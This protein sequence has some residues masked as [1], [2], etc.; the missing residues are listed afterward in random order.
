MSTL[1]ET[2]GKMDCFPLEADLAKRLDEP[3]LAAAVRRARLMLAEAYKVVL[4]QSSATDASTHHSAQHSHT[5]NESTYTPTQPQEPATLQTA[6]WAVEA[7]DRADDVTVASAL[8]HVQV[9][10]H[11]SVSSSLLPRD[12]ELAQTSPYRAERLVGKVSVHPASALQSGSPEELVVAEQ[13]LRRDE[14]LESFR[15]KWGKAP[16]EETPGNSVHAALLAAYQLVGRYQQVP[17]GG[18]AGRLDENADNFSALSPGDQDTVLVAHRMLDRPLE[19]PKK[20]EGF[21]RELS[22]SRPKPEVRTMPQGGAPAIRLNHLQ[23][24]NYRMV[25]PAMTGYVVRPPVEKIDPGN[26]WQ[27]AL[28]LPRTNEGM[29]S[30]AALRLM[31]QYTDRLFDA[32]CALIEEYAGL[33]ANLRAADQLRSSIPPQVLAKFPE[34]DSFRHQAAHSPSVTDVVVDGTTHI[35]D[36][37]IAFSNMTELNIPVGRT[38]VSVHVD[39]TEP[40]HRNDR[41]LE[42]LITAVDM[43]QHAGYEIPDMEVY[44]PKYTQ[45]LLARPD[46]GI[47]TDRSTPPYLHSLYAEFTAPDRF[48]LSPRLLEADVERRRENDGT[49]KGLALQYDN[50]AVAVIIHEIGHFLQYQQ[51]PSRFFEFKTKWLDAREAQTLSTYAGTPAEY[52]AEYFLGKVMGKAFTPRQ[53]ALYAALGGAQP[54]FMPT[55]HPTAPQLQPTQLIHVTHEVNLQLQRRGDRQGAVTPDWVAA[56]YQRLP[57]DIKL[58]YTRLIAAALADVRQYGTVGRMLG[59]VQEVLAVPTRESERPLAGPSRLERGEIHNNSKNS[60][61]EWPAVSPRSAARQQ[62]ITRAATPTNLT[63]APTHGHTTSPDTAHK[64]QDPNRATTYLDA[65]RHGDTQLPFASR[66]TRSIPMSETLQGKV[67]AAVKISTKTRDEAI[68]SFR[69]KWVKAP[70]EGMPRNRVHAALLA[71]Y[72]LLGRYQ[73]VPLGGIATR[74]DEHADNFGELSPGDQDTVFLAYHMLEQSL[75]D[76]KELEDFAKTLG[77]SRPKPERRTMPRGGTPAA[78]M[79]TLASLVLTGSYVLQGNSNGAVTDRAGSV[80][81]TSDLEPCVAVC[82]HNGKLSFLIH[83]DST[84]NKGRGAIDLITSIRK[85]VPIQ[86]G[87]GWSIS[88]IGG[89]TAGTGAYL[90][91]SENLPAAVFHDLGEADG[92][93]ITETG[94]V[95]TTKSRLAKLLGVPSIT[96]A[97]DGETRNVSHPPTRVAPHADT[98]VGM[99]LTQGD[100]VNDKNRKSLERYLS[101]LVPG[102]EEYKRVKS[103]VDTHPT[104][105]ELEQPTLKPTRPA[106]E[107]T[108]ADAAVLDT[109]ANQPQPKQKRERGKWQQPQDHQKGRAEPARVA[110]QRQDGLGLVLDASALSSHPAALSEQVNAAVAVISET[111]AQE[112]GGSEVLVKLAPVGSADAEADWLYAA[113]F[114]SATVS[115]LQTSNSPGARIVLALL[116]SQTIN[117]CAPTP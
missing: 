106:T 56:K 110:L 3:E 39:P 31:L 11:R 27:Q 43:V 102:T 58:S 15:R 16:D 98:I 6:E 13:A 57:R 99:A 50:S 73:R 84:S 17:M 93:Y 94:L 12:D 86:T 9:V 47:T 68:E 23:Q 30:G 112:Q 89:S 88:L 54:D 40:Q 24:S 19:D 97:T 91:K 60:Q 48:I 100:D 85:L 75:E 78:D 28:I 117:I 10:A 22:Q 95:A 69:R 108:T 18:I 82:G 44:L 8:E 101:R 80:L 20:L 49:F 104:T 34:I 61:V 83:S 32:N 79:N 70:F 109:P 51:N 46:T 2:T 29:L 62:A 90:K 63:S 55:Q 71:A 25:D 113:Q 35:K 81:Y 1:S 45:A 21:A 92:A 36:R 33:T 41:R 7:S 107:T 42:Q 4:S 103:V 64:S 65:P 76:A 59:G 37:N 66:Q 52:P 14:T 26:E 87:A 5:S 116:N 74:L 67:E 38:M 105:S 72:Q 115:R 96:I 77:Q 111:L 53:D 114:L